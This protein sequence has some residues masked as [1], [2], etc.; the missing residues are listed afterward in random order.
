MSFVLIK[1]YK[2]D[3]IFSKTG[4]VAGWTQSIK[5]SKPNIIREI[6]FNFL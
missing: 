6:L 3:I 1:T 2:L 4:S 5:S